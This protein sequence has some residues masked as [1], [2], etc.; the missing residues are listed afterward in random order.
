MNGRRQ[1]SKLAMDLGTIAREAVRAAAP[2]IE[3]AGAVCRRHG[4][5]SSVSTSAPHFGTVC[6]SSGATGSSPLS[7]PTLRPGSPRSTPPTIPTC[8]GSSRASASRASSR[9]SSAG[10]TGGWSRS[11]SRL[12]GSSAWSPSRRTSVARSAR[13]GSRPG[14]GRSRCASRPRVTWYGRPLGL[15]PVL[16]LQRRERLVEVVDA[17]RDVA[18]PGAEVVRAAVVVV[19]QLEDVL[20]RRRARR[21]SSSPRARRSGRCPCRGRSESRA[22]R[23]SRG[24]LG[25]GDPNHGVEEVGHAAEPSAAAPYRG[26]GPGRRQS[27]EPIPASE[28]ARSPSRATRGAL[29]PRIPPSSAIRNVARLPVRA[30]SARPRCARNSSST[31]RQ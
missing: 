7:T 30:R 11:S 4:D 14:R 9:D 20:L 13:C 25:V 22:P 1:R 2:P 29:A 27:S 12:R 28:P 24:S 16:V 15:D 26:I 18:V 23:R 31:P 10:R 19:G 6:V 21:S 8:S 17:D 3:R 5:R